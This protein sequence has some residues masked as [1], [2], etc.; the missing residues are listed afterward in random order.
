MFPYFE[1]FG[2]FNIYTF[3]LTL[4]LCFFIFMWMLK[5]LCHRFWINNSFFFNRILWYFLSIF[6]FSRIF[7]VIW[8][9]DN[10]KFIQD[11]LEFFLMSDYNFSLMW[12]IF[13]YLLVLFVT[14]VMHWLRS[15]KYMD[16][17]VLS[18]L[19]SSIFWYF[20][21]FMWGQV[22]WKET[23]FWIEVLYNS[24]ISTVPYEVP[25]FP[26][27]IIYSILFFI[28]FSALYMLAMF[29]TV[30]WIIWYFGLII[31][32]TILLILENFSWKYDFFKQE[33]WINLTQIWAIFLIWFCAFWL[34][35]I[36][37]TPVSSDILS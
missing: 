6:L 29:V 21:A 20:W 17:S 24:T 1:V 5:R 18:F 26:L 16:V 19:F 30:R 7:Y 9:W 2:W 12:A 37:K 4:T 13:G 33:I 34:Y 35:R 27:A 14:I 22:Y 8:N 11:P 10:F 31:F 25:V 36:Y 15:W 3:G 28:L 23:N 32:S